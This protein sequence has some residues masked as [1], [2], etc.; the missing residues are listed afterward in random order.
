M[1]KKAAG[2]EWSQ[3]FVGFKAKQI[4]L[5]KPT[6]GQMFPPQAPDACQ[7]QS[8]RIWH[9]PCWVWGFFWFDFSLAMP[10]FFLL[11]LECSPC[12]IVYWKYGIW[13][14]FTQGSQIR[15]YLEFQKRLWTSKQY[16]NCKSMGTFEVL[17]ALWDNHEAVGDREW[18]LWFEYEI[19]TCV[20]HVL[21]TCFPEGGSPLRACG[22]FWAWSLAGGHSNL[23]TGLKCYR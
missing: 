19:S 13:F 20:A 23:G 10:Q 2:T 1:P 6:A 4:G 3:P 12:A 11:R 21:E 18:M 8:C 5:L 9:L 15:N 22:T 16:W 17:V 14:L 7:M